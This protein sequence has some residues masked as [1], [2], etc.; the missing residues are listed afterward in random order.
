MSSAAARPFPGEL[1][2]GLRSVAEPRSSFVSF[3]RLSVVSFP[4]AFQWFSWPKSRSP[5]RPVRSQ[6]PQQQQQQQE[7]AVDLAILPQGLREI[8]SLFQS[9]SDPKAKYQQLLHYGGRLPPLDPRY[10]TDE[11][12]VRGCV[13]QVWVRAFPD[14]GDPA[15]VR[16]EADSDS[17]LTKGLAALLVLGLSGAPAPAIARIPPEFVHLLGLRQSLTPSRNNGFLNML[18]LMQL[19]ALQLYAQGGGDPATNSAS[20]EEIASSDGSVG[21]VIT[22]VPVGREANSGVN[23]NRVDHRPALTS[24]Q[25]VSEV[26]LDAVDD[27]SPAPTGGS[28]G[29]A[30]RIRERLQREL[31]PLELELEDIS[32]QHAG[33]A[34]VRGSSDGETHYN[35]RIVSKEF[36]GKT[37]VKRHRLV[38][39][40]LQE[41]LQTGLHA[42]SIV[43]KTPS[44]VGMK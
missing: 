27:I 19:K 25:E 3:R 22:E 29:R 43:A 20:G 41:E 14:P 26:N 15:A 40:L 24:I 1:I 36:E 6:Q 30:A 18:K 2:R 33:H 32:Y 7:E 13:S 21:S 44:E 11:H 12:R 17:A 28:G 9:V 42:L 23:G 39:D 35:L 5:L 34:G 37:L 38:Y 8:I 4:L 16:F 31:L 10:K